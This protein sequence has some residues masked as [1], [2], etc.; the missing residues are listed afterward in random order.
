MPETKHLPRA[1]LVY[2]IARM[3]FSPIENMELK[4]AA[5]QDILR[6]HGY[7][8][9]LEQKL[10]EVSIFQSEMRLNDT[11]RWV[12]TNKDHSASILLTKES[13][14][15]S[16]SD[17]DVYNSFMDNIV[18]LLE[19]V[20]SVLVFEKGFVSGLMIRY[21]DLLRDLDGVSAIDYL[22]P[23]FFSSELA[24]MSKVRM[25]QFITEIDLDDSVA[26]IILFSAKTM[27]DFPPQIVPVG[28]K[29]ICS[30]LDSSM[31]ILDTSY[32]HNKTEEEYLPDAIRYNLDRLHRQASSFFR[33]KL[34]TS[35]ALAIW[36]KE[37]V[38]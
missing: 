26:R 29:D 8:G 30:P 5:I 21:I 35:Q 28:L 1:P 23:A 33:E 13:I 38:K 31:L 32:F 34:I 10:H 9:F 2:V 27:K 18:A 25:R 16:V 7:P 17:Y 6:D 24:K 20:T 3:V 15:F 19:I 12:F 36:S 22:R 14:A 11:K 37:G 4:I